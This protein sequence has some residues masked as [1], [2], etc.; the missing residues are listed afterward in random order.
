MKRN[1]LVAACCAQYLGYF[2]VDAADKAFTKNS[3]W[4]V[5]KF[6]SDATLGDAL[7]GK[8]GC[9]ARAHPLARLASQVPVAWPSTS[10]RERRTAE[11]TA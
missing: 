6:E 7:D 3:Q 4:L 11:L 8:L 2:R 10:C 5:W 9:V 1:P